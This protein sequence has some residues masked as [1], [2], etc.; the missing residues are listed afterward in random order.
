MTDIEKTNSGLKTVGSWHEIT[1][2]C[3][4]LENLFEEYVEDEEEIDRYDD[5]RPREEED[6]KD[7]QE[8]TAEEAA[9]DHK[10]I[11]DDFEGTKEE[12]GDAEKK[13]IESL[14]DV[15]NGKSPVED[16]QEAVKDIEILIGAKSVDSIRKIEEAIYKRLMLKFNPYYFDTEDFS[17]NLDHEKKGEYVFCI[18][19]TDEALRSHIQEELDP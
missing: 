19:I 1:E 7:V 12:L 4:E 10:Q 8:K 2:L 15:L 5:W 6:E 13:L 3:I 17:V 16:L 14:H 9:I 11:E 18:N